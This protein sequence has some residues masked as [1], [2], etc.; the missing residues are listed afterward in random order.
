MQPAFCVVADGENYP[1][2]APAARENRAV[3]NQMKGGANAGATWLI[4][5]RRYGSAGGGTDDVVPAPHA[6]YDKPG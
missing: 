3:D 2:M 4:R 6:R 1:E 5:L